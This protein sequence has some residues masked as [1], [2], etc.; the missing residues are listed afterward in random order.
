ME[1]NL[2]QRVGKQYGAGWRGADVYA[3]YLYNESRDDY[4]RA[5]VR[6]LQRSAE[7]ISLAAQ[8]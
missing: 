1:Y 3:G 7:K 2:H 4:R 6:I 8:R 5:Y